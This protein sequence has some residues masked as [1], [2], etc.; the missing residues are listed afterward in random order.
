M[1]IRRAIART[2]SEAVAC[3]RCFFA[4]RPGLRVLLYHAIGSP[5]LGDTLGLFSVSPDIFRKHIDH[6]SE[7]HAGRVVG[8]DPDLRIESELQIA[9][10]FDDGYADNLDVAAPI[11]V[12]RGL[13]FTVF[14]TAD[15]VMNSRPGFLTPAGLR[16]LAA[17]P[18]ARIGAHGATHV[19]LSQCDDTKLFEEL[20]SSKHYL[21]DT[22]GREVTTMAYPYGAANRRVRDAVGAAG[23]LLA[24]SSYANV[25][26]ASR[27]RLM[28]GRTEV[29]EGDSLRVFRQKLHGDWDWRHWLTKDPVGYEP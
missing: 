27:D 19:A 22:T 14:V 12:A 3:S 18:G 5:A 6:L 15:F 9:I 29:L 13:P 4:P 21:E 25:N 28:L 24:A 11:L 17:M 20:R 16:E 7:C 26:D 1:S 8:L 10:T 23:Y 2:V